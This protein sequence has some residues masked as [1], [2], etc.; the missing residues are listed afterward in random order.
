[1]ANRILAEWSSRGGLWGA[2]LHTVDGGYR[3]NET[4]R[5]QHCGA[6]FRPFRMIPDDSAA[7]A[8][9]EQHVADCFDVKMYR[10][11]E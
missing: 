1:M 9:A 8:W 7:I 3:I 5:G 4:K 10:R 6:S 11:E 2:T